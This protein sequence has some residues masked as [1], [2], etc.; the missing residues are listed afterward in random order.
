MIST[1]RELNPI[2]NLWIVLKNAISKSCPPPKTLFDLQ[3]V[4]R[5]EWEKIPMEIVQTL[6]ESMPRRVKQLIKAQGFATN[7]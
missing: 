4:I 5:E 7:Y 6:I 2:E 1:N 3:A